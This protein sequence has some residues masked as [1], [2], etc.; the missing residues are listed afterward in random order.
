MEY[1]CKLLWWYNKYR[2]LRKEGQIFGKLRI[3]TNDDVHE[4]ENEDSLNKI[5]CEK[6]L[7]LT[8]VI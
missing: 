7:I 2:S 1:I 6:Y 3:R 8:L 5:C 4:N